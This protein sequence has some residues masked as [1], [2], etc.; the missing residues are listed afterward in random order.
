MAS[1]ENGAEERE[2]IGGLEGFIVSVQADPRD[3]RV[4]LLG[5]FA[6]GRSFA[7]SDSRWR[8][9]LC[10]PEKLLP[11][12]REIL[13]KAPALEYGVDEAPVESFD[14][15]PFRRIR[16]PPR[17]FRKGSERLAGAGIELLE[18]DMK[19]KDAYLIDSGSRGA[20]RV[21]GRAR[22]GERVDLVLAD[23]ALEP[24]QLI[25]ELR[26]AAID[27][28]TSPEGRVRAASIA[29][30]AD[31]GAADAFLLSPEGREIRDSGGIRLFKGEGELLSAF[32]A[33][34]VELDPDVL[35]GWNVIEFDFRVL[36][37]RYRALGIPFDFGRSREES[38]FLPGSGGSSSAVIVPGR[39][40]LD[41]MRIA[42]SGPERFE[43]LKLETVARAV[44]GRGKSMSSHGEEK[45]EE[46]E[47]LYREAP[48]DYARYCALDSALVI[49]ILE[50]TG[51]KELTQARAALTGVSLDRAWTSIPAF[52][53][54]YAGG[55][56]ARGVCVPPA[57]ERAD[58][59][60]PG[61]LILEPSP[62]LF[63]GVLVLDFKSLYPTVI[64]SF[65][66]DPLAHARA[67]KEDDIVAPNG[68]RFSREPGILPEAIG[69]Y[70]ARREEARARKDEIAVYVYKILMNSFYGVLGAGACRFARSALAAAV[71]GF[72]Q[73]YLQ[74]TSDWAEA[75]GYR[76]LYGDTDSV[77][78]QAPAGA[79]GLAEAG[80]GL[81]ASLNADLAAS[82]RAE[83]GLESFLEIKL[84]KV[85]AK[86]YLPRVR[87][88]GEEE[89]ARGR[90]KGYAGMI[91]G[92]GEI[93][94]KG[95]E[96]VRSDW[97]PLARNFQLE[98]LGL[99]FRGEDPAAIKDFVDLRV[100]EVLAGKRDEEL[101]FKRVLRRAP[102]D[103]VK[104]EPPAV[105]AARLLGWTKRR[106]T[107]EYL[108]TEAGARPSSMRDSPIDYGYYVDKQLLPMV[109]S[110]K[111]STGLDILPRAPG[112][113]Q[114]E[115]E[116]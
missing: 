29:L 12:V 50:K 109:K 42:R 111:D 4:F 113:S 28:E 7:L 106:G 81:V 64:R 86:F 89:E 48:G 45:I 95:M 39:Q 18:A 6:D 83:Y 37:E 73:K 38:R 88:S 1:S 108:I 115:L 99:V 104:N 11:R 25:P 44:L 75:K 103:Y 78:L 32:A 34:I 20:L 112:S 49:G 23:P 85:Y 82:V 40:C 26:W 59:G 70:F 91:S 52:E 90:A 27:I 114:I 110:V 35:C 15:R 22:P 51:L 46:L 92:T 58:A 60:S 98:L 94:V 100:K 62:G 96:A 72:G 105:K 57:P 97:T 54:L 17:D 107:V 74:W 87:L 9:G 36:A 14:G 2:E 69:E 21:R 10:A 68:A 16:L 5:R 116:F 80:K 102:E 31:E 43:D 33:R 55:L 65:N 79:T 47:K 63:S 71:T 53:R 13:E 76:V 77:F 41:A 66:I 93:E 101:V 3:G 24:A 84:E 8:Q 30:S 61:G 67:G 56:R 19:A